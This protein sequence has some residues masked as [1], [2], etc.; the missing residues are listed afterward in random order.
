M[1]RGVQNEIEVEFALQHFYYNY[2]RA[3]HGQRG[4][5]SQKKEKKETR[6][7]ACNVLVVTAWGESRAVATQRTAKT[8]W[9]E[10]REIETESE[11][12]RGKEREVC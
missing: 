11:R 8:P 1:E 10:K 2:Q 7:Q 6:S 3:M 5:M 9:H 12:E 4:R